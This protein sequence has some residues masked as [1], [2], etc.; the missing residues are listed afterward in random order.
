MLI[1]IQRSIGQ[2][3]YMKLT[4]HSLDELSGD[5]INKFHNM[6]ADMRKWD[7]K[8]IEEL[9]NTPE[10]VVAPVAGC[11]HEHIESYAWPDKPHVS[12]VKCKA[13]GSIGME[14]FVTKEG[15]KIYKW[16]KE[17]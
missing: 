14:P 15:K 16:G 2:F 1:E 11:L 4:L 3:E 7:G 17:S 10:E 12:V 6:V 13:C 8:A 9:L 5:V